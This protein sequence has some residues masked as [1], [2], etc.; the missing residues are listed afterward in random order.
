MSDESVSTAETTNEAT[1]SAES[2]AVETQAPAETP[3]SLAA[4]A[5]GDEGEATATGETKP[6][7]ETAQG[8]EKPE[9]E[10]ASKEAPEG[11]PEEYAEFTMPQ[12]IEM[13]SELA[14]SFK[15]VAK[16]LNLSQGA[17]QKLVDAMVPRLAEQQ[18]QTLRNINQSFIDKSMKDPEIG[19]SNWK[20]K[21]ERDVARIR[22]RF[23][24][25]SDGGMDPD[26]EEFFNSP[27]GNHPGVLKFLARIGK[28]FGEG[29]FPQGK[30]SAPGQ[31]FSARDIYKNTHI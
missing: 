20:G 9:G 6:G 13:N 3:T 7:Q 18:V 27:F 25:N 2:A 28:S 29:G 15:G 19:G 14:D 23:S 4:S 11:A 17:A 8:V 16:E 1:A 22:D 21:A 5:V 30:V 24:R 10:T 31:K 26:I 12:G